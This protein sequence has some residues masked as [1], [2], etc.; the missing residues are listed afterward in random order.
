MTRETMSLRLNSGL[1]QRLVQAAEAEG[2]TVTALTERYLREGLASTA[3]PGIVFRDGHTGRRAALAGGPDVWQ[4][5][6]ALR[7]TAGSA[8][9]RV[10]T[11]AAEFG[12]HERRVVMAL[13]YI[14]AHREE[15]DAR[16]RANDQALDEVESRAAER[17]RLLA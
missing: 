3:H 4:V 13:D 15:I 2:M 12:L 17:E 6:S 10:S 1:R 14:A 8:A 9:E 16:V 7:H 5:A 11:L